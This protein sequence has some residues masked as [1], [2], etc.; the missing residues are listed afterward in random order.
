MPTASLEFGR[1]FEEAR[2]GVTADVDIEG[3]WE[4]GIGFERSWG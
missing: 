3:D 4:V 2:L 1:I